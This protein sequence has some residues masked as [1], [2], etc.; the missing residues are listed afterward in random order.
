MTTN[1]PPVYKDA[2]LSDTDTEIQK[3][4]TRLTQVLYLKTANLKVI[5]VVA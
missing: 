3:T 2:N 5:L 1:K 4:H